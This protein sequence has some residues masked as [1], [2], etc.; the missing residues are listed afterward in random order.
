MKSLIEI[1]TAVENGDSTSVK[2][3]IK[4]ALS[5][6]ISHEEI[7]SKGLTVGME[8]VGLKFKLNEVF[9]PE[10]LIAT[11]AMKAGM[12]IIRPHMTEGH[13]KIRGKIVL[14]TVK[15]DLHDIGKRILSMVLERECYEIKDIGIDV[16]TEE[17][18]KAIQ[19]EKPDIIGMSALLTTTMFYMRDV[20]DALNKEQLRSKVKVIIGG[21]PITSSFASEIGADGY[22]AN[23]ESAVD[24]VQRLLGQIKKNSH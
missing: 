5:R 12:D 17:F 20:I 7:L 19:E 2:E 21:S 16:S 22:A 3:L 11:R 10:V 18:L 6:N 4:S 23:A 8:T 24:L 14:G 9:I 13:L 15:G 1:A